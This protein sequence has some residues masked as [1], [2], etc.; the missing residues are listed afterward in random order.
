MAKSVEVVVEEL[1]RPLVESQGLELVDV[2]F[3][4]EG[5]KRYLRLYIDKEG[6]IGLDDCAAVSHVVGERLDEVDP[7]AENY[8]FEV[9]SPGIERPLKK[10]S[11]FSRFV[12]SQVAVST[13]GPIDGEK[14]FVGELLGLKDGAIHLRLPAKGKSP[15]REV[16]LDRAKVA[17]V[18]LQVDF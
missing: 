2:E 1:A 17:K 13:Y 8:F 12:G 18:K 15:E 16:L 9:S 3:V 7:I 5:G 11:D 14:L 10:D 6:G 4:K